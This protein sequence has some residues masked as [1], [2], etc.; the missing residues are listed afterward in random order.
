MLF[1][2]MVLTQLLHAFSF[3]SETRSVFTRESLR[4]SG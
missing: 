2:T 3:R 4:T 1:T